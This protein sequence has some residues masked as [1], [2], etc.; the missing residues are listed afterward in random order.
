MSFLALLGG[1]G[2]GAAPTDPSGPGAGSPGGDNTPPTVLI[3]NLRD[4]G[5]VETGFLIGTAANETGV[6]A[7]EVSLDGGAYAT[8]TGTT[9]WSYKMPTG[10][11]TWRDHSQHT[12][13]VRSKDSAGNYSSVT[14]ITVRKGINKD[15]NGDGYADVVV[16]APQYSSNTGRAYVF[17]STGSGGVTITTAGSASTTITGEA[18]SKLGVSVATGD[19]NG[20]GFADV[21]VG[22]NGYSSDTG[23]AYVF[24]SAGSGGVTITSVTSAS[25]IITGEGAA[26]QFGYSI[27][28]GDINGDGYSDVLAGAHGCS[29]TY[30]FHSSGSGGVTI[31]SAASASRM[32]T[33]EGSGHQFGVSVATGDVNGDGFADVVVGAK[34]YDNGGVIARYGR[35]YVFHSTGS[36]GVTIT[37]AADASST[38]TGEFMTNAFFGN[39]AAIGDVDGD[40]FADIV[41]GAYSHGTATGRVYVFHSTGSGGVTITAATDASAIIT[42]EA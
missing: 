38:I 17:H 28:T 36:G 6:A 26:N 13:A 39:S 7:V 34:N 19:V 4:K 37:A 2:G 33:G 12:I 20:D 10:S 35:V 22:A 31:A 9:S 29:K 41:V 1:G 24:H 14:T 25:A 30:V 11:S 40:G 18:S 27:A 8:A 21:V 5:I 3:Q 42:G 32:I 16:G 15:I 23:R